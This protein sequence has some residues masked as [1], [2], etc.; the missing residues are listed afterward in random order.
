MRNNKTI[1]NIALV[2]GGIIVWMLTRQVSDLIWTMAKL[3][4]PRDWPVMPV[5][6]IGAVFGITVFAVLKKSE[7]ADT[8]LNEVVS[9]LFKVTWPPKKETVISTGV[10]LVMVGICSLLLFGFDTLW[11][12]IVKIFYN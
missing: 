10:I 8:F 4:V 12:T 9:E 11:G 1:I 6:I 3:P 2:L 7:K 5:D